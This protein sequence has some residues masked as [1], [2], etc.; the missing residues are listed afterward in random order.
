M[1]NKTE[2][3]DLTKANPIFS[4]EGELYV[5]RD[6]DQSYIPHFAK[7][8]DVGLDLP[9]K[10]VVDLIKFDT[11]SGPNAWQGGPD[12][13][14][15]P[16]LYPDL[17]HFVYPNGV[18]ADPHPF[19]EVPALGWAEIPSAI[20]VKLPDDAWGLIKTR[21]CTAWRQH[22]IV[23]VSTIDPGY[24]GL[25]GTLVYNPNFVPVRVYEYDPKTKFGDRLSQLILIPRYPLKR[26]ILVNQLPETERGKTGFGSSGTSV[27]KPL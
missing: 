7:D 8:G 3:L 20:S 19:L 10:I 1:W 17:K 2:T 15:S 24:V 5:K 12:R 9:V 6:P 22:L 21:S 14:R 23:S 27:Q 26:I 16:M 13:L 25:L 4:P 11:D 18:P